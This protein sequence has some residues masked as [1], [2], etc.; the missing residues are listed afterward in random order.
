MPSI[1]FVRPGS[2]NTV[3]LDIVSALVLPLLAAETQLQTVTV[4]VSAS[5][6]DDDALPTRPPTLVYGG[7]ETKVLD[8][9]RSVSQI[10]AEQLAYGSVS[11]SGG[12]VNYLSKKPNFNE[13]K[14][15]LSDQ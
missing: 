14:T 1:V 12:Y 15:R 7:T 8:T 9:P 10:N 3:L 11:S 2:G 4:Q 13:F 6:S 5:E